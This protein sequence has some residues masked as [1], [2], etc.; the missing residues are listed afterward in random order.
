MRK[1]KREI[2]EKILKNKWTEILKEVKTR[3]SLSDVT[4]DLFIKN[5]RID[6]AGKNKII[7]TYNGGGA[8]KEMMQFIDRCYGEYIKNVVQDLTCSSYYLVFIT[9]GDRAALHGCVVVVG[10]LPST[11]LDKKSDDSAAETID[12]KTDEIIN[13]VIKEK[14]QDI[15]QRTK[16]ERHTIDPDFNTWL[17]NLEFQGLA[18]NNV[19]VLLRVSED[20]PAYK[21]SRLCNEYGLFLKSVIDEY[22]GANYRMTISTEPSECLGIRRWSTYVTEVVS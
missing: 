21:H 3:Y 4:Y 17:N 5:L 10:G 19:T 22:I 13:V 15:L 11:I 20:L 6:E 7:I 12:Y 16:R 1:E 18:D 9:G 2:M 8:S 14:W